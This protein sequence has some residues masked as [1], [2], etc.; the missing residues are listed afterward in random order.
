MKAVR[1][2]RPGSPDVINIVDIDDLPL[3]GPTEV[4][5]D[6]AR[7]GINGADVKTLAGWFP[8]MPY[9]RGL[10]REFSGVVRLVGSDVETL[11]PGQRVLGAVEPAMQE[12]VLVDAS[13]VLPMPEWLSF[14]IACTLPVAAQ[15][16]WEAVDSQQV[17]PGAV[18]V[19]SGASGGV[20]S[21]LVQL[22]VDKGAT[23]IAVARDHHHERLEAIGALPVAWTDRLATA[24]EQYTPQGIHHV[25]D[26]VGI[27]VIEAA[28]ELGVPRNRINSV[29]G[30]ADHFGVKNV[31]RVGL[32]E[33]AIDALQA[34]IHDG[35]LT[36]ATFT[37]PWEDVTNAFTAV[38]VGS[39]WGK[40]V[41]STATPDDEAL[42]DDL[43]REPR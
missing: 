38:T 6:V 19:V 9:P 27:P 18:C 42:L 10:G 32:N 15:T 30:F 39:Y 40:T 7:M 21:I 43:K 33:V 24:L 29:S 1:I 17:Q 16:A 26:Q 13:Q 5:V 2:D 4:V 12:K 34:M 23:V 8:D 36:I 35:R 25:F 41:L 28:L 14:D 37:F 20:G 3:P 31:G 22:L 11:I